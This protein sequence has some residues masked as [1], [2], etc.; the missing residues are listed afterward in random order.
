MYTL[1]EKLG[2]HILHLT[3]EKT[4][5]PLDVSRV[6]AVCPRLEEIFNPTEAPPLY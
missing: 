6:L 5:Y 3:I 2:P 1:A 4:L